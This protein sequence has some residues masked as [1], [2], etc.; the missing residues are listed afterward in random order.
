M[1]FDIAEYASA[2]DEF[3]LKMEAVPEC[4]H[5]D[6]QKAMQR[7][8]R[9]LRIARVEATLFE[10]PGHEKTGNGRTAV[11]YQEP[12]S[13]ADRKR[14]FQKRETTGNGNVIHY[15]ICPRRGDANWTLEELERVPVFQKALFAFNGRARVMRIAEKLTFR[16][17]D[18]GI[19]NLTHFMK[20]CETAIAHNTISGYVACYF[21]MKSFSVINQRIGRKAGTRIM[22]QFVLG[23]QDKLTDNE[24]VCR[25]G[26]DNFLALCLQE[27]EELVLDYLQGTEILYEESHPRKIHVKATVGCYRIPK[28]CQRASQIMDCVSVAINTAKAMN[29]PVVFFNE[30]IMERRNAFKLIESLFPDAVAQEEFQVY[31]QPKVMLQEYEL[32]GAEALCRWMH[33]GRMVSPG[34]FIPVLEQGESICVLDFYMLEHV[35]RD[36]RRWLDEG[37]RVVTISVNLSR[38]HMGD[39][40]LLEHIMEII[41]RY[42]VPH[43]YI[44][45][46]L[47]ETTTD[48]DFQE[49]KRIVSGLREQGVHTAVDDFGVGY[50]SLNLIREAPWNVLKIDKSFLPE[51]EESDMQKQVML[52]Y[53]ISMFQEMGLECIVEGVETLKQ[54]NLLKENHCYLAQGFYFDRP[55]PV[56][57]FEKRLEIA[58]WR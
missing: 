57:E 33:D 52:K 25:I 1:V 21:N 58:N 48:V 3:I 46:E 54:V 24:W 4:I 16:D 26:G 12:E 39:A 20:I 50:S 13:E 49:L 22:R 43:E 53:I 32:A 38:R 23:L 55:L 15:S 34:E 45:I 35:C 17:Q 31:Y 5:P 6:T 42:Q 19:W 36:I 8:C 29:V 40:R 9:V 28:E 10:T 47:T 7:I 37:R 2:L 44:E 18:M 14:I 27:H 51:D 30:Q 56:Q 11:F 41:D